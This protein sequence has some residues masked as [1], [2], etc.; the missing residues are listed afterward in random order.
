MPESGAFGTS[1]PGAPTVTVL[2]PSIAIAAPNAPGVTFAVGGGGW[3][4]ASGA[5]LLAHPLLGLR[6]SATAPSPL[7]APG[8]PIAMT[9]PSGDAATAAP[10]LSPDTPPPGRSVASSEIAFEPSFDPALRPVPASSTENTY[11]SPVPVPPASPSGAPTNSRPLEN[12]I[13]SPAPS[14]LEPAALRM[15]SPSRTLSPTGRS[16]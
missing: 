1:V 4:I 10:N 2:L 11:T 12:T 3:I 14:P 8:I 7:T 6:N 5:V 15:L 16:S 9:S 13:A